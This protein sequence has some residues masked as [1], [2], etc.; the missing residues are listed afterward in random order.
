M[1]GKQARARRRTRSERPT[2]QVNAES[3][4]RSALAVLAVNLDD[5][6]LTRVSQFIVGWCRAAFA[7][8]HVI[9][10]LAIGGMS[11][12][13]APNRR[14]FAELAIR[15]QWLLDLPKEN[16]PEAVDEILEVAREAKHGTHKHLRDMGWDVELDPT[17]MDAF[18][19]AGANGQIKNQARKFA[20][21]A[22]ATE[23]KNGPVFAMWRE[24]SFLAHPTGPLAGEYAPA[25]D[26][27]VLGSGL[28][29]VVDLDLDGHRHISMLVIVTACSLLKN[30]GVGDAAVNRLSS[31]FFSS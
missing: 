28:P 20:A 7:Q 24:D 25:I 16:R 23:V 11:S 10:Q 17:E 3:I 13:S 22:H 12:A 18:V 8:S 31:A 5:V 21:A 1:S 2:I 30:E 19:L 15:L 14:L 6:P 29:S 26:N 4:I 9:G 27:K